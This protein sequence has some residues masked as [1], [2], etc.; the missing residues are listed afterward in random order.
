[1]PKSLGRPTKCTPELI[2]EM[3]D[4]L[5][6]GLTQRDACA[7]AGIH[8]GTFSEWVNLGEEGKHPYTKFSEAVKEAVPKRKQALLATIAHHARNQ[9]QAAAWL[10]ERAYPEEYSLRTRTEISGVHGGPIEF[11]QFTDNELIQE[12]QAI[13]TAALPGSKAKTQRFAAGRKVSVDA[14]G[15]T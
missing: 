12:F 10:L 2:Q 1:M 14:Q 8:A 4:L 6:Q 15:E 9:W 3:H 5:V 13:V 11:A 7:I